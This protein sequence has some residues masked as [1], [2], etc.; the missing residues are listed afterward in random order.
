M[1]LKNLRICVYKQCLIKNII[2]Y[3]YIY[4]YI[5]ELNNKKISL[6]YIL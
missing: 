4:I 3:I 2:I 5:L 1:I 6:Q